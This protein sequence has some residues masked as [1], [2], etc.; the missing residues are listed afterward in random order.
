MMAASSKKG[1]HVIGY[2]Y[3]KIRSHDF[4]TKL[5]L[6]TRIYSAI[7]DRYSTRIMGCYSLLLSLLALCPLT[8]LAN[9]GPPVYMFR[10]AR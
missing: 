9:V 4:S 1:C 10:D 8:T 5:N 6:L 2:G 3:G 7:V